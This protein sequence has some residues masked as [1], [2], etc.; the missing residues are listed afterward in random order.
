MAG[1][2]LPGVLAAAPLGAQQVRVTGASTMRYIELR[3]LARDSVAED[4]VPGSGLLRQLPDGRTV[5]CVP[6]DPFCR[7]SRPGER[8]A[9]V[10][11][12]QDL[13]ASAW[14]LG[15]GVRGFAH[16]RMRSALGGSAGIWP[17]EDD[18]VELLAAY[19]ELERT[20]YRIRAGRQWQVSGLGF[21]NFDGMNAGGEPVARTWV[22]VYA[23]RSLVRGMNESRA[24][25]ALEA[26][27][28]FAPA[29]HGII[30]GAHARYRPATGVALSA[31]YQAD[32]RSDGAGL[33][34][35]LAALHA[36]WQGGAASVEVAVETD[37]ATLGLNEARVSVHASPRGPVAL[38]GEL[39]RYRPYFELWTI[40]GAFSPVG[41][42]EA[43]FGA[44]WA[45]SGRRLLFRTDLAHRR[46]GDAG[47]ANS[48][49][50]F[51]G[52][53]WGVLVGGTWLPAPAWRV[54]GAYRVE[55]GFGAAR[56]DGHAGVT[57]RLGTAGSLSLQA[58][59]FQRL[60]EFRLDEGTVR[61]VT[62]ELALPLLPRA[63]LFATGAAYRHPAGRSGGV[64]WNQRR[65][66]LRLQWMLGSEPSLP[67]WNGGGQ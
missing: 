24:G 62:A 60:Y 65:G 46:Y 18:A 4:Q 13:E 16:L 44:T 42:D 9:A 54:D 36:S 58:L 29:A 2:L 38:H 50:E 59:A 20:R 37:V 22:E 56:R 33:F 14:G 48:L 43:R 53:G 51:R 7:Y 35:E 8:V 47:V 55:A 11:L 17:Q 40:W 31:S 67:A 61:G 27:E 63:T 39:R 28:E 41:F 30:A 32:F 5:R 66:S 64:D 10:P 57:R 26:I 21:Y 23:G 49:D 25:G 15:R 1:L 12:L 45:A 19:A 34:A 6:G 3:P 52:S